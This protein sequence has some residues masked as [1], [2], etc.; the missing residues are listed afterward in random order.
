MLLGPLSI[1]HVDS[2]ERMVRAEDA[3]RMA[4]VRY[5][6]ARWLSPCLRTA[7]TYVSIQAP[8]TPNRVLASSNAFDF[9]FSCLLSRLLAR[10]AC[11]QARSGCWR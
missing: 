8:R 10:S 2:L 1:D 4:R 9:R 6:A 7:R 3:G 11:L 5:S